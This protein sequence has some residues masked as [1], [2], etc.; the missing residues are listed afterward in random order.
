MLISTHMQDLKDTTQYVFL[1]ILNYKKKLKKN[2]KF[3]EMYITKISERNA[4]PKSHNKDY[5][6]EENSN[7]TRF[8]L[9]MMR[10]SQ[11]LIVYFYKRMRRLVFPYNLFSDL[12]IEK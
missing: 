11:K 2:L 12:F 3:L 8:R 10:V 6:S 9:K 1:K 4:F 5:V 7:E